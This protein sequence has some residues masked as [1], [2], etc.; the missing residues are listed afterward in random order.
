MSKC[1]FD[2]RPGFCAALT[3]KICRECKFYKTEKEFKEGIERAEELL[4]KKGLIPIETTNDEGKNII[5]VVERTD[6]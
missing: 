3:M 4:E 5:S 1:K 2:A 6:K